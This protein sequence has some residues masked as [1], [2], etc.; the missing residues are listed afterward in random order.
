MPQRGWALRVAH[1]YRGSG[2]SPGH[3]GRGPAVKMR[4]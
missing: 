3:Q 2:H 1:I 4:V